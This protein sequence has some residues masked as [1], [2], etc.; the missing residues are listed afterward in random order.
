MVNPP[1][2]TT[3]VSCGFTLRGA[4]GGQKKG[5]AITSLVLGVVS[6]CTCAGFGIG[7]V[8]GTIL[9]IV[10]LVK[11]DRSPET[12]GGK[13]L[14]ISGIVLSVIALLTLPFAAA[15]A[16]PS[17]LRARVSAN[18]STAIGD[19][20]TVI[21]A[22]AAY[23][24]S[25][26]GKYDTL[27][28]LAAPSRCIPSY[29]PSGPTFLDSGLTQAEKT[30]YRRRFHPGPPADA[31]GRGTSYSPS[32]VTAYAY[33]A[34]PMHVGKTGVRAFCGD[35]TGLVCEVA[36]GR[37]SPVVDGRCPSECKPIH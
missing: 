18:E 33:V 22:E 9:G 36:D 5:L 27:Q 37:V 11:A 4:G 34:E 35:D 29:P 23:Q 2:T 32:S 3:C 7:A 30:G 14:A 24:A 10:A 25:N 26:A 1:G 16:I 8:L 19:I 13:G 20:R 21:S 28:C 12:H 17:L 6:L 31:A 15:I